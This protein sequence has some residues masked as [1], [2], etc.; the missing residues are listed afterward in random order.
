MTKLFLVK[1]QIW[2]KYLQLMIFCVDDSNP[3]LV[4]LWSSLRHTSASTEKYSKVPLDYRQHE[5]IQ[6]T[7][8]TS[9]PA[10]HENHRLLHVNLGDE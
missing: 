9:D 6:Q 7:L 5:A 1:I 3:F 4:D 2:G 10:G 8:Q